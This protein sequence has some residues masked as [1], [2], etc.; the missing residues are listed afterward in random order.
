MHQNLPDCSNEPILMLSLK[1]EFDTG[2]ETVFSANQY[3]TIS[4]ILK[5][6][7]PTTRH[8]REVFSTM[9]ALMRGT[10]RGNT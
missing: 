8:P 2:D 5:H 6:C 7:A 3:I 4:I 10:V 1:Q 9:E